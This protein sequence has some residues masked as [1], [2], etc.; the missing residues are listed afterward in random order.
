MLFRVYESFCPNTGT[1]GDQYHEG[2]VHAVLLQYQYMIIL[3]QVTFQ[4]NVNGS[5][6]NSPSCP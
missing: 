6:L 4:G 1:V 2:Q 5:P 3:H